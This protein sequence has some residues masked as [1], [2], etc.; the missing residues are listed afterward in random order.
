MT[1]RRDTLLGLTLLPPGVPVRDAEGREAA[2]P[3]E[4]CARE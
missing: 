3:A 1:S 4:T 2:G